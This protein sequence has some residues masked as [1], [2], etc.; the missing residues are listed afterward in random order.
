MHIL[1]GCFNIFLSNFRSVNNL[2]KKIHI[3]KKINGSVGKFI[4]IG[5]PGT[6]SDNSSDSGVQNNMKSSSL[7][8]AKNARKNRTSTKGI[9]I[10]IKESLYIPNRLAIM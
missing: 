6:N 10:T 3:T 2:R 9:S 8:K 5:T 4:L 7:S 1:I